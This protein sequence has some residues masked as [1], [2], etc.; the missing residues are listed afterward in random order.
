MDLRFQRFQTNEKTVTHVPTY[1]LGLL[2][3]TQWVC[4]LLSYFGSQFHGMPVGP[5]ISWDACAHRCQGAPGE[6]STSQ[7]LNRLGQT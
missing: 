1:C 5:G 4:F 7:D 6:T 3:M 2:K